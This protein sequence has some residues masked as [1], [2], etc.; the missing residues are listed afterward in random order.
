MNRMNR[1]FDPLGRPMPGVGN[2]S[3]ED[4]GIPDEM[5]MQRAREILRELRRRAGELDRPRLERDYLDRLLR[6]F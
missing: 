6:R 4:V 1:A 3:G 2:F 5:E